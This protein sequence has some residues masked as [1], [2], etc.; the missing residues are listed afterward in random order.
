MLQK[1]TL[2]EAHDR[3]GH[4]VDQ[5][6]MVSKW[7]CCTFFND[8]FRKFLL[9][10]PYHSRLKKRC[11]C[12]YSYMLIISFARCKV[13]NWNIHLSQ[14]HRSEAGPEA[15]ASMITVSGFQYL[16]CSRAKRLSSGNSYRPLMASSKIRFTGSSSEG[17]NTPQ[18]VMALISRFLF[19]KGGIIGLN[20]MLQGWDP[21]CIPHA[22]PF[23]FDDRAFFRRWILHPLRVPFTDRQRRFNLFKFFLAPVLRPD[24][25]VVHDCWKFD[26]GPLISLHFFLI[27]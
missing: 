21:I 8:F 26:H 14:A 3:L 23:P 1:S 11:A 22:P 13:S 15:L 24:R 5:I 17:L 20:N 27:F 4:G 25:S 6:V 16:Y 2:P 7:K 18:V 9:W 19:H 10:R 12:I